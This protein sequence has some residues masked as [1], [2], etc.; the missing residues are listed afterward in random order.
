MTLHIKKWQYPYHNCTLQIFAWSSMNLISTLE[1]LK[2]DY[3]HCIYCAKIICTFLHYWS[4]IKCSRVLLWL[5]PYM[6]HLKLRVQSLYRWLRQT[7]FRIMLVH[8]EFSWWKKN[9]Y[10]TNVNKVRPIQ[11]TPRLKIHLKSLQLKELFTYSTR[12]TIL[13]FKFRLLTSFFYNYKFTSNQKE[14]FLLT[15]MFNV[16]VY[17]CYLKVWFKSKLKSKVVFIV[18]I[19]SLSIVY[20]DGQKTSILAIFILVNG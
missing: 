9:Q 6:G 4:E 16:Y 5:L 10:Y 3:F 2:T 14:A 19:K 17:S 18:L 12:K 20:K 7:L 11:Y 8:F 1:I 13:L 15:S